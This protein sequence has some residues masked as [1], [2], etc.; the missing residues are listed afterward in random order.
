MFGPLEHISPRTK[1]LFF[2]IFLVLLPGAVLSY[3][4]FRSI[5]EKAENLMTTYRGTVNLV[6]D[7]IEAEIIGLEESLRSSLNEQQLKS[8]SFEEIKAWLKGLELI[9]PGL[10][11]FFLVNSQGGVVSTVVSLGWAKREEEPELGEISWMT[12]FR[13]AEESEFVKKDCAAAVRLYKNVLAKTRTPAGRGFVLSRIGR[14]YFKMNRYREG[15]AE[16][17]KILARPDQ[18]SGSGVAPSSIVALSQIADGYASLGKEK[19]REAAL[20]AL[21]RR[22]LDHPWDQEA[23]DYSYY[24]KSTIEE[25][26]S[27]AKGSSNKNRTDLGFAELKEQERKLLEELEFVRRIH[28]TL[29]PQVFS[30]MSHETFSGVA[31]LRITLPLD[32]SIIEVNY[33]RLSS[34]FQ[35]LEISAIGYAIDE[36]YFVSTLL[37]RVLG[38]VDLGKDLVVGILDPHGT[39]RYLQQNVPTSQYLM[40]EN[41]SKTHS[42]WK[43]ALFHPDGKTIE[44]L[45]GR[46]KDIY[47]TLFVGI[48]AVMVIGIVVIGRAAL[49][50]LEA[51]RMKTEFVSS[52]SHELKTP[53]ALIRMFGE[54]LES[55]LVSDEA[56]RQEFYHII[57]KESERLTHLINNVLDFS[58]V[59]AGSKQ[60]H[61]EEDDIVQVAR[62]TLEA[63]RFHIRDL[64]FEMVTLV[65]DKPIVVKIDKD[66]ISQALLNLLNNAAKYSEEQKYIRAEVT[67]N[68][69]EVLISV[70]DRGVGIPE[71]E[72][73]KV[74]EKF[75]RAS[76]TRTKETTGSGLGLTLVKHIAEAH[77]GSVEVS[78]TVGTGS[79]FVLRL[80]LRQA[81]DS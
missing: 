73:K 40:A 9:H 28:Q 29:V 46:E 58:K 34:S 71:D 78:S 49:H 44:E 54:T 77:A 69:D 7:R 50:E 18:E 53:L 59:E 41:F 56:R 80:P 38:A 68:A 23:G 43:V 48:V 81:V 26:N 57:T 67:K 36:D 4:G 76:T 32:D 17:R 21:Y 52:V 64:G 33:L 1:I 8:D 45:V 15:I 14:C 62:S 60:Y 65:P 35:R 61:F 66:A 74:F 30:E 70:E 39:P 55:G 24:L 79:R 13:A 27:V 72:L 47:L 3:L 19:E 12:E 31:P 10:R 22:L 42:T 25:V 2:A 75:Y 16:Y 37:P 51:S 5:S 6:R 11:H 20:L 63:Y